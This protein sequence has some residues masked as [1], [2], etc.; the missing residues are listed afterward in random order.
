VESSLKRLSGVQ[1]AEAK[2][3]EGMAYVRYD[4]A[5]VSLDELLAGINKT[6]YHATPPREQ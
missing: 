2:V 3:N 1:S 5:R 4:P 6:G